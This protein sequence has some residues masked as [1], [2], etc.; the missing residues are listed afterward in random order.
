MSLVVKIFEWIVDNFKFV[1]D[2]WETFLIFGVLTVA[3]THQF[4]QKHVKKQYDALPERIDLQGQVDHLKAE[5]ETLKEKLR[6][7]QTTERLLVGAHGTHT[8]NSVGQL[9]DKAL[10]KTE[11]V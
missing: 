10:H 7:L 11:S 6:D 9:I 4:T 2:N 1:K 8:S 5:N 3:L